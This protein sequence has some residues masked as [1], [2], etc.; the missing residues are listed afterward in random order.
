MRDTVVHNAHGIV[1]VGG[2]L[3]SARTTAGCALDAYDRFMA[4]TKPLLSL[5]LP[6]LHTLNLRG[7]V[8]CSRLLCLPPHTCCPASCHRPCADCNVGSRAVLLLGFINA[9]GLTRL[10]MSGNRLETR[11]A[12]SIFE[13]MPEFEFANK[14]R[15]LDLSSTAAGRGGKPSCLADSS[16]TAR[17]YFAWYRKP[18]RPPVCSQPCQG[19]R[20]GG[21]AALAN[22]D[23][24]W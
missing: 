21:S 12:L 8:H 9:P 16:N 19:V 7:V 2:S 11:G 4:L 17:L 20:I 3:A 6:Q 24:G 22:V 14:L 5:T 1:I 13:S 15:H 10:D 18:S 23:L